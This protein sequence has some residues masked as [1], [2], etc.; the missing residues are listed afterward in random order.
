MR[1]NK[2]A[3]P[4][5]CEVAAKFEHGLQAAAEAETVTLD[6]EM[7]PP[8]TIIGIAAGEGGIEAL[9]NFLKVIPY[10]CKIR[11]V[12][13]LTASCNEGA[14]FTERIRHLSTLPVKEAQQGEESR[15]GHIYLVP[16]GHHLRMHDDIFELDAVPSD[17]TNPIDHFLVSLAEQK[18]DEA[19]AIILSGTGADGVK[20]VQAIK[21][22][23]GVVM[24]QKPDTA[25]SDTLPRN[26]IATNAADFVLAP[27]ALADQML[28]LCK[29][30]QGSS[31]RG[32]FSR[33]IESY[34]EIFNVLRKQTGHDFSSYKRN[35]ITR[36]IERRMGAQDMGTMSA[37]AKFLAEHPDEVNLLFKELL[38]GVTNFFRDPESF[39]VQKNE[40][41]PQLL[42]EKPNGYTVR[43]WV[44]GCSTG[45]EAYSLAIILQEFMEEQRRNFSVQIFATDIDPAAIE[46]A[47]QGFFVE[48]IGEHV[49]PERLQKFFNRDNGGY[50][51][52]RSIREMV[53]FAPQ[54]MI[55]DPPFTKL[56]MICCR[57]LLIYLDTELQQKLLPLYH[58]SLKPG[59][60]L[61][62][63]PSESVGEYNNLFESINKKWKIFRRKQAVSLNALS[64]FPFANTQPLELRERLKDARDADFAFV[65]QRTLLAD[66]AP[67]CVV[68]NDK[69]VISYIHGRTGKFLEPA[70]GKA[71]QNLFEMAREGLRTQLPAAVR[72]ATS[73]GKPTDFDA[74]IMDESPHRKIRVTVRPMVDSP[75]LEGLVMVLFR[76]G[77]HAPTEPVMELKGGKTKNKRV[78]TLE[79]ELRNTRETLHNT[80]EELE[81]SNEELRSINE[82]YQSTN[83]EL[84]STNEELETSREELQSLNEEL[85]TVNA[86]LQDKIEHLSLTH[87]EMRNLLD[88]VQLPVL[89]LDRELRVRRFTAQCQDFV[90]LI[91]ADVGRPIHHIA[92]RLRNVNL[93]EEAERVQDSGRVREREVQSDDGATHLL[94]VLPYQS[95]T[96]RM[97]GVVITFSPLDEALQK[98][99]KLKLTEVASGFVESIARSMRQPVMVLDE[100]LRVVLANRPFFEQMNV[101][102][103]QTVGLPIYEISGGAW[104]TPRLRKLFEEFLSRRQY[105]ENFAVEVGGEGH[106]PINLVMNAQKLYHGDTYLNRILLSMEQTQIRAS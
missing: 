41:L 35:T 91:E 22:A 85:T 82:E 8:P 47:R 65:V 18:R 3:S 48:S 29:Y 95:N 102:A 17:S 96:P 81:T 36:R 2:I 70:Q 63:G 74:L 32:M 97:E 42:G 104:D 106:P 25:R 61:F 99:E 45:E 58:Y 19:I 55:K 5:P 62:L 33:N 57:N 21:D 27:E 23:D 60:V 89:F 44:P 66:Y 100:D 78:Q 39:E 69:G 40:V 59:G 9:E 24:I 80:I 51:I 93:V 31:G 54:N 53:I 64:D 30:A 105:Y 75:M 7:A 73:M 56:D 38:I 71:R 68:I 77:T 28:L 50:Q 84:K 101:D 34:A 52:T 67:S 1:E 79:E 76:D 83:E 15:P 87:H 90:N 72:R 12:V 94:R 4:T 26:C 43:V 14:T 10:T 88:S 103:T 86:E 98:V 13:V 20:G 92:T 49:S 37:Y 46:R 11:F 6:G 16:A